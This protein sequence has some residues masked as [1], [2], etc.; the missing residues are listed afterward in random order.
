M[1]EYAHGVDFSRYDVAHAFLCQKLIELKHI[2]PKTK[3]KGKG[4]SKSKGK[5]KGGKTRELRGKSKEEEKDHEAEA[6]LK[7]ITIEVVKN[8]LSDHP[9][10]SE[11]HAKLEELRK[12]AM[13]LQITRT[14]VLE[15]LDELLKLE[16]TLGDEEGQDL[17]EK[18]N[19]TRLSEL[20]ALLTKG[21]KKEANFQ[22][23][24]AIIQG[25]LRGGKIPEVQSSTSTTTTAGSSSANSANPL[26]QIT[27]AAANLANPLAQITPAAANS[28]SASALTPAGDL[29]LG[30]PKT[31]VLTGAVIGTGGLVLLIAIIVVFVM[32]K[33]KVPQNSS[34]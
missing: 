17:N 26:G 4:K 18:V 29:L 20:A 23:L 30:Y 5:G 19:D 9:P 21:K 14:E 27:P 33:N 12:R 34:A 15:I 11:E 6:A 16:E 28:T 2:S 24:K 10:G 22:E 7:E 8:T 3:S 13:N 1:N 31:T 32:K 25:Q